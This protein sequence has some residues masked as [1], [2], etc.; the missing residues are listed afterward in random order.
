LINLIPLFSGPS[1][2]VLTNLLGVSL[3]MFWRFYRLAGVMSFVL[4][5]FHMITVVVSQSSFSLHVP[6]NLRGLIVSF[7]LFHCMLTIFNCSLTSV[8]DPVQ[9]WQ[10]SNELSETLKFHAK[11]A[12]ESISL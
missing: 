5:A 6:E 7:N 11:S 9:F 4:L 1:F 3:G 12:L 8:Q 10:K 2:N